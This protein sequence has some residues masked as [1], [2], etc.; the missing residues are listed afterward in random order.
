MN[1]QEKPIDPWREARNFAHEAHGRQR[2]G[3]EPY[4]FHLEQVRL[5]L[6][7]F[8][9]VDPEFQQAALLHDVIEDTPRNYNDV[10]KA[11]G[12]RVAELV[13]AV[14]DELGRDRVERH[15]KTYPKI[16]ATPGAVVIKL[17]DRI[18]NV[19][20]SLRSGDDQKLWMYRN[21]H[22]GFRTSLSTIPDRD[23]NSMWK[24]LDQIVG[25]KPFKAPEGCGSIDADLACLGC[26]NRQTGPYCNLAPEKL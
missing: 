15:I 9:I 13:Y 7:R 21:E 5:V 19:E 22:H 18:A 24:W 8:S 1:D 20:H 16:V 10:K 23:N 17:A 25:L 4:G 14:T 12:E 6:E 11:F 2:Y 26:G 3:S